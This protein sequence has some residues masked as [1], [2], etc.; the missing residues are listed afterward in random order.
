[1]IKCEVIENFTLE[2]FEQLKNVEK[3]MNRKNN[4]FGVRDTFECDKEMADY[5]LGNNVFKKT[6]VRVIEVEPEFIKRNDEIK[7]KKENIEVVVNKNEIAKELKP[8]KK[9]TSKK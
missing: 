3:V 5:L 6:V 7:V 9:K 2:K 4:E 8:K 1:M